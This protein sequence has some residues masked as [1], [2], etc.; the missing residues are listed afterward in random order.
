MVI[1]GFDW[2]DG[3]WPKCARH[4]VSRAEI[5]YVL[6]HTPAVFPDRSEAIEVRLNAIGRNDDG[7]YLF[8]VFTFRTKNAN[9]LIRPISARYMHRKEVDHY[10]RQKTP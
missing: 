9:T 8:I 10:E 3:N 6:T 2:D 1:A 4:G 5:E 7:R